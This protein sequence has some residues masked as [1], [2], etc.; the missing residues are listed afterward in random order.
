MRNIRGGWKLVRVLSKP[1]ASGETGFEVVPEFDIVF[2]RFPTEKNFA[3]A[4]DGR[5]INQS[6]VQVFDKDLPPLEVDENLLHVC[7]GANPVIYGFAA[8]IG[9]LGGQLAQAFLKAFDILA[10][11]IEAREPFA[12]LRQEG[13]G[14]LSR[15]M[16]FKTQFHFGM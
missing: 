7:E 4:D 12:D 1:L 16:L 2:V 13:T 11:L 3:S 8:D 5:E 9:G 10:E 6:T 14:F 15:V